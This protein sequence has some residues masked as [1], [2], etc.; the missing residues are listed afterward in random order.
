MGP[1]GGGDPEPRCTQDKGSFI[2]KGGS[3]VIVEFVLNQVML[4]KH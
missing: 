4:M 2:G 3:K 1:L